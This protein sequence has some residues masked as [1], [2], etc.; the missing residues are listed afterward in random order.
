MADHVFG[1][2]NGKIAFENRN[3]SP[4]PVEDLVW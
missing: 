1:I 4:I 2:K 3:D